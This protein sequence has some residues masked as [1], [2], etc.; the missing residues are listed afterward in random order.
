MSITKNRVF[1]L[2]VLVT[3][4]HGSAFSE[5]SSQYDNYL[6]NLNMG[7]CDNGLCSYQIFNASNHE[8]F[9][10]NSAYAPTYLN[11][12]HDGHP[13]FYILL[14]PEA[15]GEES[16]ANRYYWS[17]SGSSNRYEPSPQQE[18]VVPDDTPPVPIITIQKPHVESVI[19]PSV[20][21]ESRGPE[22]VSQLQP[23][24][25]EQTV[26]DQSMDNSS[27]LERTSPAEEISFKTVKSSDSDIFAGILVIFI[28]IIFLL[29]ILFV[30]FLPTLIAYFWNK[31]CRNG[32]V[33]LLI[34]VLIGW[35]VVGWL[36]A[37]IMA[38]WRSPQPYYLN[39]NN[40]LNKDIYR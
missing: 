21:P 13:D 27:A 25:N 19:H 22:E 15:V 32:G 10:V 28:W 18:V 29:V 17:Y 16:E 35:T 2:A 8:I 4:I 23:I 1:L 7:H 6:Q 9:S 37:L 39:P 20:L 34:N 36:T 38:L 12:S 30:Y 26:S 33:I 3:L 5:L 31:E 11:T 40:P 24:S 14:K